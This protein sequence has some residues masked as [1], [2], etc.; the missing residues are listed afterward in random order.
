MNYKKILLL[1]TMALTIL[2]SCGEKTAETKTANNNSNDITLRISWWGGEDRHSKTIEAIKLFEK[3]HPNIKVKAEYGGWQ[4]WQEKVTTQMAGGIAP[5]LMQINWNWINIFSK[6]GNGFYNLNDLASTIDLNQYDKNLLEQCIVDNKLN[7]V[8]FGVAGRVFL[9]NKTT[10]D[11]AGLNI[12]KSFKEIET[13][14][15]IMKEKLGPD[16]YGFETDYYGALL[17]M[18]YKLE[19]ETGKPFIVDNKVAYSPEQIENA[20]NFYLNLVNSKT[21]PSLEDRAAAGN[22]QLDQHPSWIMGKFGGTYEWDSASLK[23]R[24]SLSEGQE[25]VVGE[26]PKDFGP[27]NSGFSKVSMAFAINKTTKYP[28]ETAQLLEFLTTDPEAVKILGVSR[29][30]PA[31]KKAVSILEN[32]NLLDPFMLEANNKVINFAG[33]GIHPLFEHKQLHVILKDIVDRLG[34]RQLTAKQASTELI[35]QTND[36]LAQNN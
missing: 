10:Y 34:Y 14:T 6:D 4:G 8:P 21:I 11:K 7:A 27:N 31:N 36:F 26:Y 3:T 24:D 18:L 12:P 25:L 35:N 17:L 9:Y 28:K 15:S 22:I 19:Q 5:D 2:T 32:S 29:G 33:K 23:W 20:A 13:S 1:G 30:I 16:Y